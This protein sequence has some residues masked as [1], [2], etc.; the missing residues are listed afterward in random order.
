MKK[1]LKMKS[2]YGILLIGMVLIGTSCKKEIPEPTAPV[3]S[4]YYMR[5]KANGT[6]K[7]YTATTAF[8]FGSSQCALNG[9]TNDSTGNAFTIDLYSGN[10]PIQVNGSYTET[11]TVPAPNSYT[12]S[13]YFGYAINSPTIYNYSSWIANTNEHSV[14]QCTVKILELDALHV[15][16][17]FSGKVR[18]QQGSNFIT[19][20]YGEFNVK[21]IF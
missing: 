18:A 3:T 12:P 2:S 5:F 20:S 9:G 6:Q 4:E 10:S 1:T 19:I 14:Y 17:T 7:E 16:G 21:R 11:E 15:K 8:F 13:A